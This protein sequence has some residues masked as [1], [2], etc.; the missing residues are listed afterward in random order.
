MFFKGWDFNMLYVMIKE[1]EFFESQIFLISFSG[2]Q[3]V[4]MLRICEMSQSQ[5]VET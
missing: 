4:I 1:M 3:I 5:G 2:I